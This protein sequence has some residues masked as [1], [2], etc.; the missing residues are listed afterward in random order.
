MPTKH[1]KEHNKH[2]PR[3]SASRELDKATRLVQPRPK[4][5]ASCGDKHHGTNQSYCEFC[6][7]DGGRL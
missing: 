4:V 7:L 3:K 6:L 1:R 5:C 2:F